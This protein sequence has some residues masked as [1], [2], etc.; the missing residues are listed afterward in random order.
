[1]SSKRK[2]YSV[3]DLLRIIHEA[4]IA[5]P[6]KSE[7]DRF[8]D[9]GIE[10]QVLDHRADHR[11][12][13]SLPEDQVQVIR[14]SINGTLNKL[15]PEKYDSL[16]PHLIEVFNH[17]S[18]EIVLQ[19]VIAKAKTEAHFAEMYARTCVAMCQ[20]AA[21][22]GWAKRFYLCVEHTCDRELTKALKIATEAEA[23]AGA[24]DP[25]LKVCAHITG[26]IGQLY[27]HSLLE[28]SFMGGHMSTLLHMAPPPSSNPSASPSPAESS[29]ADDP[30][31]SGPPSMFEVQAACKLLETAGKYWST[32]TRSDNGLT[33]V[34]GLKTQQTEAQKQHFVEIMKVVEELAVSHPKPRVKFMLQDVVDL[35]KR[36]WIPRFKEIKPEKL[37]E[38]G[39]LRQTPLTPP[40]R[41]PGHDPFHLHYHEEQQQDSLASRLEGLTPPSSPGPNVVGTLLHSNAPPANSNTNKMVPPGWFDDVMKQTQQQ[42]ENTSAERSHS[43][44]TSGSTS[45]TGKPLSFGDKI[46]IWKKQDEDRKTQRDTERKYGRSASRTPPPAGDRSHK[47]LEV[48]TSHTANNNTSGFTKDQPG[49]GS[50]TGH[51]PFQHNPY[52]T[53]PF[54][55]MNSSAR[56]RTPPP[57][58]IPASMWGEPTSAPPTY[59]GGHSQ[60]Q[61]Q[62]QQQST[63]PQPVLAQPQ[64]PPKPPAYQAPAAAPPVPATATTAVPQ[65]PPQAVPVSA[66]V[67]MATP[68]AGGGNNAATATFAQPQRHPGGGTPPGA[69]P[70]ANFNA[71][72]NQHQQNQRQRRNTPPTRSI[73][74]S[75]AAFGSADPYFKSSNPNNT[76]NTAEP[77]SPVTSPP[78]LNSNNNLTQAQGSTGSVGSVSSS[79]SVGAGANMG[80]ESQQP[81]SSAVKPKGKGARKWQIKPQD[82][83]TAGLGGSDPVSA[84]PGARTPPPVFSSPQPHPPVENKWK[85]RAGT[86]PPRFAIPF[87]ESQ[88][89]PPPGRPRGFT[90][91][92]K[93]SAPMAG[94]PISPKDQA[95]SARN[96][97]KTKWVV[98]T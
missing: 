42:S 95:P 1:M 11:Y 26:C 30:D 87:G 39:N 38:G 86:P 77:T 23:T 90:P 75:L 12:K 36:N 61:Q 69:S 49:G 92:P 84:P 56:P 83:E 46:A 24:G 71:Y 7:L 3:E 33:A 4:S 22:Q 40:P 25:R 62:P 53:D 98:K 44:D 31:M 59:G 41:M 65:S 54:A 72:N 34:L 51:Q 28:E 73:P 20:A 10:R 47:G 60:Q 94:A 80:G 97:K 81:A 8:E 50:G 68:L 52:G 37:D 57:R 16:L 17:M 21:E 5:P 76:T 78:R 15:T 93:E 66:H 67:P 74:V 55:K 29:N 79:G 14:K 32:G 13:V 82:V 43:P 88:Q 96:N 19:L 91:P 18:G 63:P 48:D 9:I 6:P 89:P 45:S 35:H 2:V 64:G 58:M 27:I 85:A 70:F